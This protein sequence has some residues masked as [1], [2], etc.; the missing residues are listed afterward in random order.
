M[1]TQSVPSE[2]SRQLTLSDAVVVGLGSMIGAGVFVAF[3][4][5]AKASGIGLLIALVIAAAI[6]YCNAVASAQ[7]AAQY[8]VSG[9]TY[10][11]GRE[12]LNHWAGFIAGWGFVIGKTASCTAMALTFA[13]YAAPNSS[14]AQRWIAIA[15]VAALAAL[16]YRGVTRTVQM[17]RILVT[18]TLISL[19]LLVIGLLGSGNVDFGRLTDDAS[20]SDLTLL[21]VLQAAG[22]LFF[23]FAGYARIATMGEEV[24]A[25]ATTIPKAIPIALFLTM[26]VYAIV[27]VVILGAAG[28][29]AIAGSDAPLVT[30]AE[31]GNADWMEPVLRI[32]AMFASMGAL[33][34]LMAGI[35][36]TTL[37]MARNNDLPP[38]LA[39]VHPRFKVPHVAEV[40]LAAVVIAILLVADIRGA[41]GFS[42]FGVL[43]YYSIANL[44]AWTQEGEH[45][46]WPRGLFVAGFLGCVVLAALLPIQSV[47]AGLAVYAV[48]VTIRLISLR[49][50]S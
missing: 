30:A 14:T 46:R 27:A 3:G 11:Y 4:P 26:A 37:A 10:V 13:T 12:R 24:R 21:G 9:G 15:V 48:G 28:P 47:L 5:A 8:P 38:F 2:L 50:R 1:S 49:V 16:N 20:W 22:F 44:S 32:G 36:R 45:R 35:G 6:A 41:I 34:G 23:A 19:S 43:V 31:A 39:A 17:T 42:S 7:L 25:P 40:T 29:D 18:M 33:L